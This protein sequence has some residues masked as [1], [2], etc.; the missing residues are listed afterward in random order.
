MAISSCEGNRE[1]GHAVYA[2]SKI[3][4]KALA[5][6]VRKTCRKGNAALSVV[7]CQ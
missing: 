2:S 3:Q 7:E 4:S 1:G 6:I 5:M